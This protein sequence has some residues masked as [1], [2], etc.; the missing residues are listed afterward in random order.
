MTDSTPEVERDL[1]GLTITGGIAH[2]PGRAGERVRY[3]ADLDRTL[4]AELLAAADA[5]NF[6]IRPS[7][8]GL[9]LSARTRARTAYVSCMPAARGC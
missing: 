3:L 2:F 8:D 9:R 5:C 1:I 6:F 7:P 4:A